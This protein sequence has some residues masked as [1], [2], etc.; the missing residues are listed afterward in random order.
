MDSVCPEKDATEILNDPDHSTEVAPSTVI[1]Y[2]IWTLL[3]QFQIEKI[4]Q[5]LF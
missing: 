4:Q 3:R 2:A 1:K 5:N